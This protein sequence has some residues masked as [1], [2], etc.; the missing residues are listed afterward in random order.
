MRVYIHST[1][2][3]LFGISHAIPLDTFDEWN[4]NGQKLAA[5]GDSYSAGIGAG[6]AFARLG[7]PLDIH[8]VANHYTDWWCSRYSHS[9]PYLLNM[10]IGDLNE[11]GGKFQFLSCSGAK[12]KEIIDTQVPRLDD[13]QNAILISSG[14]SDFG[15]ADIINQCVHQLFSP[16]K[17]LTTLAEHADLRSELKKRMGEQMER[18]G[19][20]VPDFDLSKFARTCEEQLA[21]S[22]K[23]IEDAK[24]SNGIADLI[25]KAKGKL[26]SDG[27]IFYTS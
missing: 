22:K 24:F 14:A 12:T 7:T 20:K 19:V 6:G 21:E 1:A 25:K 9:Y 10:G 8:N 3:L 23:V 17:L 5:V 27:L 2:W 16:S 4:F 15:F 11:R 18:P 26:A 13:G